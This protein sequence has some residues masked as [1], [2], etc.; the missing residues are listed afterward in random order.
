M[1]NP[2]PTKTRQKNSKQNRMKNTAQTLLSSIRSKILPGLASVALLATLPSAHA[3]TWDGGGGNN[4]WTTGANWVGDTAP[5]ANAI[6]TFAGTT[7]LSNNNTFTAATQ[8]NG[9]NFTNTT[10]AQNFR[11]DGNSITLG[12]NIVTTAVGTGSITDAIN[13]SLILNADRTIDTATNHNISFASNTPTATIS[14]GG[15]GFGLIKE[16]ASQLTLR[17]TTGSTFTGAVT[18]NAGI[19]QVGTTGVASTI[20]NSGVASALGA[21]SVIN[22]GAASGTA[23]AQ[24]AYTSSVDSSSNRTINLGATSGVKTIKVTGAGNLTLTGTI[25]RGT[26]SL[27]AS[28]NNSTGVLRIDSQISGIGVVAKG[29]SGKTKLT[30]STSN[31]TGQTQIDAGT[32]EISSIANFGSASSVGF[33]TAGTAIRIGNAAV[34]ST[35]A[36]VGSGHSSNRTIQIGTGNG[37]GGATLLNNG[38]GNLTFTAATPAT[39]FNAAVT[40]TTAGS[41]TLT[42]GG[43]YTGGVNSIAGAI[44]NNGGAGAMVNVTKQDAGIWSLG[45][46]N[47]Y[48]GTTTVSAGTLLING[49]STAAT[50]ATSVAL[51]AAIGG[52][53]TIGGNL[54]LAS[55]AKFVFDLNDT[56]LTVNGT[57]A[58]NSTFGVDDLVTSSLGAIDWSA[59]GVGTY[60]LIGTGFTFNAGNIENFGVANAFVSGGKQ[61]YFENGSLDLVVAVPEPATWA[62]LAGSLTTVMFLRR[63]RNS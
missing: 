4:S 42:L 15:S 37:A 51:G 50:G 32:L 22:L 55:G 29:D 33:G 57:F 17:N 34:T 43:N 60:T 36:Y 7:Q 41:R 1:S 49:N 26:Q 19:L 13:T 14:D 40:N 30:S 53:G 12:G 58:L 38:A 52:D 16:G 39:A 25:N 20:G 5:V 31:Y 9:I 47:T 48:N 63:R 35:L 21:G 61:I 45:G 59:V 28:S 56:P 6:L 62:L 44:V 54:T 18:I 8:F 27:V 2:L 3:Q 23:T 46:T 10:S 24:L 11:L